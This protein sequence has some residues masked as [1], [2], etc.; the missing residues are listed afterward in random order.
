MGF[1]QLGGYTSTPTIQR[2]SI[3]DIMSI[4]RTLL[5]RLRVQYIYAIAG[6]PVKPHV[7]GTSGI[8]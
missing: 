5:E 2:G 3:F 1:E 4:L 7:A 6:K 8:E